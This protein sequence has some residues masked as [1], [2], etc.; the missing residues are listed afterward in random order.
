MDRW[1][2]RSVRSLFEVKREWCVWLGNCE[3]FRALSVTDSFDC[4]VVRMWNEQRDGYYVAWEKWKRLSGLPT[5]KKWH[6]KSPFFKT[7]WLCN[8]SA[9]NGYSVQVKLQR[10]EQQ[11]CKECF[12]TMGDVHAKTKHDIKAW[13]HFDWSMKTLTEIT[14]VVLFCLLHNITHHLK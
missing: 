4:G 2:S 10:N 7:L 5:R 3:V 6:P 11:W 8:Y 9:Q 1:G 14:A 13:G 12:L